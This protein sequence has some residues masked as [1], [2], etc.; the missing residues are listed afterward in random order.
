MGLGITRYT[1]RTLRLYT[2][3][4]CWVPHNPD[5]CTV[6]TKMVRRPYLSIYLHLA[7]AELGLV[8]VIDGGRALGLGLGSGSG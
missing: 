7:R 8:V 3:P 1:N 4:R 2:V 6:C 5:T